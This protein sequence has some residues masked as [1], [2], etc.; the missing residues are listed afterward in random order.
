MKLWSYFFNLPKTYDLEKK[1]NSPIFCGII[2]NNY[3]SHI[4]KYSR[5]MGKI[6][7]FVKSKKKGINFFFNPIIFSE[8]KIK[9]FGAQLVA[10]NRFYFSKD[11]TI[12]S[13][14]IG[15]VWFIIAF[16]PPLKTKFAGLLSHVLEKFIFSEFRETGSDFSSSLFWQSKFDY[17]QFQDT[18]NSLH[19]QDK[20]FGMHHD[21]NLF[22]KCT[23]NW[24]FQQGNKLVRHIFHQNE[25]IFFSMF[26]PLNDVILVEIWPFLCSMNHMTC[27]ELHMQRIWFKIEIID[28]VKSHCMFDLT[29]CPKQ[30]WLTNM[31]SFNVKYLNSRQGDTTA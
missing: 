19:L 6:I 8:N 3:F 4:G 28:S 7:I 5:N 12:Q 17:N 22:V 10:K 13:F 30:V 2:T 15:Q 16:Y 26:G 23:E 11:H 29:H 24:V 9:Y 31:F 25:S 18:P 14:H 1:L 20:E 27:E 21:H